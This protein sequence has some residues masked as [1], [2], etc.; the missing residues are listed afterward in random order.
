MFK[1]YILLKFELACVQVI[2][3][4]I[5]SLFKFKAEVYP[6]PRGSINTLRKAT[7]LNNW[8]TQSSLNL[9]TEK[10]CQKIDNNRTHQNKQS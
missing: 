7:V 3:T 10:S 6:M 5:N 9:K 4:F 8:F 1:N 2:Q